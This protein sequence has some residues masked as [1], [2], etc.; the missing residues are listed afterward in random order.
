MSNVVKFPGKPEPKKREAKASSAAEVV[1][2]VHDEQRALKSA[3]KK[4]KPLNLEAAQELTP[5]Q[6]QLLHCYAEADLPDQ[7][8]DREFGAT[9]TRDSHDRMLQ[10][11]TMHGVTDLDPSDP[12][13]YDIL[14]GTWWLL[15]GHIRQHVELWHQVKTI[16]HDREVHRWQPVFR[17]YFDALLAGDAASIRMLARSLGIQAGVTEEQANALH[18]QWTGL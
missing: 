10:L 12:D 11:F 1:E 4:M 8:V 13:K 16:V 6:Q 3:I 14:L 15:A 5:W 7:Y 17:Q 18:G 2:E 9:I